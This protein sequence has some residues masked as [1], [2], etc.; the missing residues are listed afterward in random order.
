[1]NKQKGG[2]LGIIGN[3]SKGLFRD[4]R[5]KRPDLTKYKLLD[6]YDEN[7]VNELEL[8]PLDGNRPYNFSGF[9]NRTKEV[10]VRELNRLFSGNSEGFNSNLFKSVY[11]V[12]Y[13]DLNPKTGLSIEK[14]E[15]ISKTLTEKEIKDE[16]V[17]LFVPW[18]I[19]Y[20]SG[21]M[22]TDHFGKHVTM[23]IGEHTNKYPDRV[24]NVWMIRQ[25]ILLFILDKVN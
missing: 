24:Q 12:N 15:N 16:R 10:L 9:E 6:N 5:T 11:G 25:N 21:K 7:V 2:E 22:G 1:M 8:G 19:H 20:N 4:K 13:D 3:P 14:F 18:Y 17:F 23:D